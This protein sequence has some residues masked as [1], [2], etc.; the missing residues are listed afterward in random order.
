MKS[1]VMAQRSFRLWPENETRLAYASSIGLNA[2]EIVNELLSQ[3]L[4]ERL[5]TVRK[6]QAAK[7]KAVL[8]Q[9]VP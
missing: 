9:P 6:E 8:S 7:L 2:S 4:R 3:H 1:K 5:E